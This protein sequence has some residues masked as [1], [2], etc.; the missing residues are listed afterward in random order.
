MDALNARLDEETLR[1]TQACLDAQQ[2]PAPAL[3][4]SPIKLAKPQPFDGTRG[5]TAEVF[6]AQIALHAITYPEC[7]PT[8]ASKVAFTTLFMRDYAA[9]WCQPYLNQIFNGQLL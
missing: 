7:F 6:V 4:P 9:T 2:Q 3:A 1:Q 8:N 5:A